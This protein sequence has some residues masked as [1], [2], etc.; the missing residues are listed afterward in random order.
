MLDFSWS[1]A[2]RVHRK[3]D[4]SVKRLWRRKESGVRLG[5]V[6]AHW[7]VVGLL[8]PFSVAIGLNKAYALAKTISPGMN[9]SI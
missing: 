8:K 9:L 1:R 6:I 3:V 5:M 2:S 7:R 4:S